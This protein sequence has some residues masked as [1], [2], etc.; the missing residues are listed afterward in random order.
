MQLHNVWVCAEQMSDM[1]FQRIPSGKFPIGQLWNAFHG[2]RL[3]LSK[4]L[5]GKHLNVFIQFYFYHFVLTQIIRVP[6]DSSYLSLKQPIAFVSPKCFAKQIVVTIV[7]HTK[8]WEKENK[9]FWEFKVL[10]QNPGMFHFKSQIKHFDSGSGQY[11]MP[12][13]QHAPQD[14]TQLS[15]NT[16]FQEK[17]RK[18]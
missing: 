6:F 15:H 12:A 2:H 13:S 9:T 11:E 14:A 3:G 17:A 8:Y 4:Y 7:L 1:N 10:K 18:A 5:T 16:S